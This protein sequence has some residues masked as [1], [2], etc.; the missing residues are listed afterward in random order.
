MEFQSVFWN[1]QLPGSRRISVEADACQHVGFSTRLCQLVG[2]NDPSKDVS[3][4]KQP[5]VRQ[6]CNKILPV[7]YKQLGTNWEKAC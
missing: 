7:L 2:V 1:S 6:M 3:T 5:F 4:K